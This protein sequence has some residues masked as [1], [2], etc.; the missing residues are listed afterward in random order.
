MERKPTEQL[1]S[2]EPDVHEVA[3]DNAQDQF[4]CLACDGIFDVFSNEELSNYITSRLKVSQKYDMITAEIVDTSLHKVCFRKKMK[5]ISKF[6]ISSIF[7]YLRVRRIIC[8]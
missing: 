4:I 6:W 3:R 8:L 2:P 5:F 7:L 1:V